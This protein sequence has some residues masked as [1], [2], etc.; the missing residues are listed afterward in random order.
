VQLFF[1]QNITGNKIILDEDESRHCIKALRK[2]TGD[3]I[4]V[5]DG[6]GNYFV[7]SIIDDNI[8]K[9]IAVINETKNNWNALPCKIS[10]AIAIAKNPVRFDWFC[11]KATE[12]GINEIIP[13]ITERTEKRKINTERIRRILISA[14]KQSGR[15]LL[16]GLKAEMLFHDFLTTTNNYS[17]YQKFIGWCETGEEQHLKN[18]YR[19]GNDVL[20]L[21]GPEGD[22]TNEEVNV[23]ELNNFIP[24]S[25]GK[26]RLRLETAGIVACHIVNLLNDEYP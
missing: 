12:I 21:I 19:K 25:L 7:A 23:A 10:I 15:A 11:E 17:A 26:S 13:L 5:V 14:M 20:L 2:K 9:T 6:R 16:P 18:L 1:S 22:F 3:V 8:K 4:E 24:V